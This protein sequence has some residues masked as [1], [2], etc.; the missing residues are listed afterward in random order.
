[1][2]S[3]D[4]GSDTAARLRGLYERHGE[5]LRFLIVGVWN[6]AFSILLYNILLLVFGHK[7]YLLVFWAAWVVAVLQSTATMKYFAFRRG[8]HFWRQAG[9]AYFIYLP[10]QGLSTLLLWLGVTVL[11]LSPPVAQLITV[12]FTTILSYLGHKYFTFRL[13][14]EVG[15][16][17]DE[18]LVVGAESPRERDV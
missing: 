2:P 1:M 8:G 9:R 15:E 6:T 4:S 16:V 13:P 17:P 10:A 12:F 11:H 14:L 18:E 3:I 5:K 7:N